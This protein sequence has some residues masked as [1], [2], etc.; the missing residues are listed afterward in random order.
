MFSLFR[1]NL[2]LILINI[3]FPLP[4]DALYQVLLKVVKWFWRSKV[5]NFITIFSLFHN[6]PLKRSPLFEQT[7]IPFNLRCFV[8]SWVEIGSVVLEKRMKMWKVYKQT[9]RGTTDGQ[10]DERR[11]EN[12]TWKKVNL[13]MNF[14]KKRKYKNKPLNNIF[15][16]KKKKRELFSASFCKCINIEI[17]INI[18]FCRKKKSSTSPSFCPSNLP[19]PPPQKSEPPSTNKKKNSRKKKKVAP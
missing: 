16:E 9:D 2:A 17:C 15:N 1:N 4:K 5:L 3:E 12:L 11:S 19:P 8:S 10:I 14:R 7:W 13:P 18:S 6:S